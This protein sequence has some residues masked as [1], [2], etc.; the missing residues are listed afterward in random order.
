M[1]VRVHHNENGKVRFLSHRDTAGVWERVIRRAKLPI[2]Y[3]EG[4]HTRPK[5]HFGLA[6]SV[7]HES[8]AEYLD[9]D[10]REPMALDGLAELLSEL[11]PPG[12][13]ICE[14]AE[15]VD[16]SGS[17]QQMVDSVVWECVVPTGA[18][19]VSARLDQILASETHSIDVIRKSKPTSIDLRPVIRS[20]ESRRGSPDE[21]ILLVELLTSGRSV[22]PAEFLTALEADVPLVRVR[23]RHQ[24]IASDH[25]PLTPM[26][27]D[28]LAPLARSGVG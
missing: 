22:R 21:L 1:R 7:G 24:F 25:G 28:V 17:L 14:V 5:L 12:L 9:I 4:F 20:V 10:L 18:D 26:H 2:A 27:P 15:V 11:M 6:L 13:D 16:R 3:T 23:R 8:D 19:H